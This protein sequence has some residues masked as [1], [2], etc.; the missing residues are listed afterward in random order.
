MDSKVILETVLHRE[1]IT[2]IEALMLM[3]EDEKILPELCKAADTLNQR[4]NRTSV[5][6][7]K[8]KQISYTNICRAECSFCSFWR[9]KSQKGSF[10]LGPDD[11]VRQIREAWPVKQVVLT[12]GLNPDLTLPYHLEILRAIREA[13]PSVHIHGYSP[14]EIHFLARRSRMPS[15]DLL[16]RFREAGLD[17]LS[18]DSADILN[19]KLRKKI[20]SDKLRTGDWADVIRT[21]HKLGMTTT[22]T[23]L[24]GHVED[25]IYICEHLEIIKNIQRETGGFTAFEPQAFVPHGTDLARSAKIKGAVSPDRVLQMVAISRIFFSRLIKHISIDWT[26]TGLDLAMK[27][28]SAGANDLGALTYDPFEIR[29]PEI[30]GKGGVAVPAL[31]AAIQK[32]G[33]SP[34]ERDAW[35]LRTIPAASHAQRREELVLA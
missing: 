9:K 6:Y 22:A 27:C 1:E 25:E 33:R 18:G 35:T 4:F 3:R 8:S 16:R 31:R 20:C 11:V 26:K 29:L 7:V 34:H 23:I 5:T 13:Y 19:D 24:F 28:L 32:A 21:A 10:V 17:S 15:A 2:A 30:N 12:G 14:S